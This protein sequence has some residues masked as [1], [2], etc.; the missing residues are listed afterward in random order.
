MAGLSWA[1]MDMIFNK[2]PTVLGIISGAGG[3]PGRHHP[4]LGFRQPHGRAVHRRRRGRDLL[5]LR[6]VHEAKLGYDDGAGR[7]RRAR[8]RR[9][10]GRDCD[11]ALGKPSLS[12]RRAPT[13]SSMVIPAQFVIQL[14]AAL[15]TVVYSFVVSFVLLKIVDLVMACAQTSK[16]RRSAST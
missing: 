4:R 9:I 14:K 2:R 3:G 10:L 12:M 11:R 16:R 13:G 6:R 15:I 8:R 7:V 1:L 5:S